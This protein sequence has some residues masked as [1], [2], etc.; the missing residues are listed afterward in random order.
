MAGRRAGKQRLCVPIMRGAAGT[1]LP[2]LADSDLPGP[3]SQ[4]RG[5]A[6]LNLQLGRHNR[7]SIQNMQLV[8]PIGL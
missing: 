8:S 4:G 5:E 2:V 1:S 3:D 6:K 7:A